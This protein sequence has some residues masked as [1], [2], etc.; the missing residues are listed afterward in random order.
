MTGDHGHGTSATPAGN[1]LATAMRLHQAGRIAEA[2]R[3]YARL[4]QTRP[5][6]ADIL[7][8]AGIAACQRGDARA[9]VALMR[10]A[11]TV[12]P[13]VA[14]YHFNLGN[15]LRGMGSLEEAATAFRQAVALNPTYAEARNNLGG[16]L[17][18]LGRLGEAAD[19]FQ[20]AAR[21]RPGFVDAHANLGQTLLL[22]ERF[23]GALATFRQALALQPRHIEALFGMGAALLRSGKSAE[24]ATLLAK[25]IEL[26]PDHA[27]AHGLIGAAFRHQEQVAPAL[28]AYR[29]AL[30]AD[31]RHA[32]AHY[33][34]ASL[35][36]QCGEIEQARQVAAQGLAV[37]PSDPALNLVL[38]KCDRRNGNLAAALDRLRPLAA[39]A[40]A[41]APGSYYA[42]PLLYELGLLHDR[43]GESEAAFAAFQDANRM[44]IGSGRADEAER[45]GY[46]QGIAHLRNRFT[47]EWVDSW[48]PLPLPGDSE[49][50]PVF[51][52][53]FPRSGT[54]LLELA[55]DSHPGV[56]SLDERP[57]ASAM[58][59]RLARLPGGYPDA[60]ATLAPDDAEALRQ[61][62]VDRA[63]DCV[64]W[65]PGLVLVDKLP[66]RTIDV[67][68]LARVF[69]RA[70]F[71]LALRH[72]CDVCL[73][74][75][76]QHFELNTSMA[77][78]L[79]LE[80]A[81]S[82]YVDVMDL[83]RQYA[84]LLPIRYHPIRYEDMVDDFEGSMRQAIAFIG[85]P[86]DESIL[87]Y[88]DQAK[89][90]ELVTTPSYHQVTEPIYR[91]ARYRWH[92]YRRQLD[93]FLPA[94]RPF[95]ELFGYQ[96]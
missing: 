86:W 26:D 35:L 6:D 95:I 54:T 61:A 21:L 89:A 80:D 27:G 96:A 13:G 7:H 69:P 77:N 64:D 28:A 53:G 63:R 49:P 1:D 31:R 3:I 16:A 8:L 20:Q 93:P 73:S 43:L 17:K 10:R 83:W 18:L 29:A 56:V 67:A 19:C 70:T 62:Y 59:D 91:R 22:L 12:R 37:A 92:N 60:L 52:V 88:R 47:R 42:A 84:S 9:G 11:I 39:G 82:L 38:A 79:R 50:S 34:L 32:R 78:F 4:L 55:L 44:V 24:A 81:V 94:L 74:C 45:L 72:P 87:R 25:V 85:L 14:D 48:R 33:N 23:D 65:R 46:R 30:A 41:A 36:E 66:L 5:G 75:F 76:M 68:A 51:L 90:R 2:E 58:L 40:R 15:A 57:V 71:L